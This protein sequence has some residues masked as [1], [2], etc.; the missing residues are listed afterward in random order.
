MRPEEGEEAILVKPFAW[1]CE[2][3]LHWEMMA[4]P[5]GTMAAADALPQSTA[6][7]PSDYAEEAMIVRVGTLKYLCV[8]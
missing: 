3:Y 1:L 4:F 5:M 7:K 8:A 6:R 2:A